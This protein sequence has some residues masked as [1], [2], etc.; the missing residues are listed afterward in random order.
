MMR[1]PLRI[2]GIDIRHHAR[3]L[4]AFA[5]GLAA[6]AVSWRQAPVDRLLIGADLFFAAYLALILIYVRGLTTDTLRL[7][8]ASADEGMKVIAPVTGTAILLS[9]LA[10]FSALRMGGDGSSLRIVL[11]VASVPLGWI[12]LHVVMAFH[13]AGVWYAQ[14]GDGRDRGGLGF[15]STDEPGVWDFLYHSFTVGMTAQVSDVQVLTTDLRRITIL[16]GAISFFY[17][18]VLLALAVSAAANLSQ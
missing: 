11:A 9:L 4:I 16:H 3:F 13:Y 17:N 6:V 2:W 5:A 14:T 12:T 10:I 7:R 8:G 15:P 18:T 1:R